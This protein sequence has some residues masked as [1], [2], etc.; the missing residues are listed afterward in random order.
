M[1]L[2]GLTELPW[3]DRSAHKKS[4]NQTDLFGVA[5]HVGS[6][7]LPHPEIKTQELSPKAA[8][9]KGFPGSHSHRV[10]PVLGHFSLIISTGLDTRTS[11]LASFCGKGSHEQ[12]G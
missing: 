11:L 5:P 8:L 6:S 2:L 7:G 3:A 10:D 9:T 12:D 1:R 4:L